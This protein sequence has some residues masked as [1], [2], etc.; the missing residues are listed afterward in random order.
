M[1]EWYIPAILVLGGITVGL[2]SVIVM[3]WVF[4]RIA[5]RPGEMGLFQD[6]K[7]EAFT[8]RDGL[9]AVQGF[10]EEPTKEENAVLQRTKRFLKVLGDRA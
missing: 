2:F 5:R 6:P 1:I 8:I 7:G 4:W 10:P 9:D 3:A